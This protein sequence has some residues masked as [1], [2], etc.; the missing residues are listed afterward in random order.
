MK[1]FIS[2]LL[3]LTI[4]MCYAIAQVDTTSMN[5]PPVS[6][7]HTFASYVGAA[8]VAYELAVRFVPTGKTLTIIGNALKWALWVSNY[9]DKGV[10]AKK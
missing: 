9:F 8:L 7:S 5:M 6:T 10:L 2:F 1:K 4:S 3:L